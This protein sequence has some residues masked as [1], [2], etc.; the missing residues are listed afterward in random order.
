MAIIFTSRAQGPYEESLTIPVYDANNSEM[1]LITTPGNLRSTLNESGKR[2]FFVQPGDYTSEGK[3][4]LDEN[5]TSS[6][7]RWLIYYDPANPNDQTHPAN[8]DANDCAT[9]GRI[10]ITGDYWRLDRIRTIGDLPT[11]NPSIRLL[12]DNNVINRCLAEWAG[13][14]A[15]QIGIGA[16]VPGSYNVVQHSVIRNNQ[17]VNGKDIHNL[18]ISYGWYNRIVHNEFYNTAGDH[19][20]TGSG[21]PDQDYRGTVI[22]D[23]DFYQDI[24]KYHQGI[25]SLP[26]ENAIDLKF[27]GAAGAG[28]HILIA[29]NRFRNMAKVAG[30]TSPN[31]DQG[32]IDHSNKGKDKS[33]VLIEDNIFYDCKIPI[34]SRGGEEL[35]HYTVRRN[36]M[37]KST[38]FAFWLSNDTNVKFDVYLNTV[39][40]VLLANSDEKWVESRAKESSFK[41][42]VVIDG[43]D[44]S[45]DNPSGAVS[46]YN[47]FYNSDP[48]NYE[49]TNSISNTSAS[50][51]QQTS[52]TFSMGIHTGLQ[53]YTIPNAVPTTSSPHYNLTSGITFGGN[54]SIGYNSSD[55][56]TQ[57]W[58]GALPPSQNG[59]VPT[60][61]ITSHSNND[62]VSGTITITASAS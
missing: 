14:G 36:L 32:T 5:G 13:G 34:N 57:S 7:P 15:G 35:D 4:I 29:K 31:N 18:K 16:D 41:G 46:D 44:V 3:V 23:N 2:I 54:S 12:S 24:S 49:G 10:D 25:S 45:N 37:Y 39:I 60:V 11:T 27:G 9:L 58:A 43:H 61:S 51:A 20:Q 28:N 47:A 62:E 52:Y 40:E 19:I 59:A 38:R 22:Y 8:M 26:H 50:A 33:Y 21:S 53:D 48:L 56:Y 42:N 17:I 6:N 55:T 1:A 30:G